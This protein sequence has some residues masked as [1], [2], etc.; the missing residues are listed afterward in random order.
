MVT[1][2]QI[3]HIANLC[4]LKFSEEEKEKIVNEFNV[5]LKDLETLNKVD[6]E[7]VEPTLS[8]NQHIQRLREDVVTESLTK[9]E[10]LE[11]TVEQQY[12]YF[13]LLKIVE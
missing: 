4:K 6:L 9:E 7:N 8:I 11:N 1:K 13:K 10:V 2:E 5:T 12:G 3:E